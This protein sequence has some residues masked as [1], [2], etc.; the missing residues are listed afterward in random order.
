MPA[1][2]K[3]FDRSVTL[4]QHLTDLLS[5]YVPL[6][7]VTSGTIAEHQ[8]IFGVL[9]ATDLSVRGWGHL[10]AKGRVGPGK[11]RIEKRQYTAAEKEAI[12]N[13]AKSGEI[14]E[15]RAFELLG[16]PV[17]VYLKQNTCWRCVPTNVWEYFIGGYQVIKKWLSYREESILGR[18]LTKDEAREVTGIIRRLAAIVLITDELNANYQVAKDTAH[19]WLGQE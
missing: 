12:C 5:P 7:G 10:D 2:R 19:P 6:T 17:D 11:G 13:G 4:G 3:E 14:A 8:K 15:A 16:P 18:S 1:G 9:S